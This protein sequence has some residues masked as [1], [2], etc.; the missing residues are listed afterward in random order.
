MSES[1][2]FRA[3]T[4]MSRRTLTASAIATLAATGLLPA[5]VGAQDATP[6][7][8]PVAFSTVP[9]EITDF[10]NDWPTTHANLANTRVA[11]ESGITTETVANLDVAWRYALDAQSGF[12][13]ITS[14]PIIQG[15][16]IYLADN[17]GAVHA[18]SRETG[19]LIWRT[20]DNVGTL[21]PNGVAVGYGYLASV[22]GDTAEVLVRKADTGELVWKVQLTT[23]G[24]VGITIAPVIYDG[25]VIVST[26]PGGNS[27][28]VYQGGATGIVYSLDLLT[29]VENWQFDTT[30]DEL[31]GNFAVNSGGGLWYPPAIDENGVLYMGVGNPGPWP[32]DEEFPNAVSRPGDNDYANCIVAL[33]PYAGKVLWYDNLKPHDL[34]DH[35]NQNSP[36]LGEVEVDGVTRKLVFASGKHGKIAAYDR[37]TGENI[38]TTLVGKHENDEVDPVPDEGLVV[39]PGFAG[40]V[41][42]PIAF[43]DGVILGTALNQ[44]SFFTPTGLDFAQQVGLPPTTSNVYAI[45]AATGEILWDNEINVSITGPGPTVAN[46]IFF[47]GAADGLVRGYAIETGELIWTFQASA[48]INAVFA[49]AGDELYIPAGYV[50]TESEYNESV[51]EYSPELIKLALS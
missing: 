11:L 10:A 7:A 27:K 16:T 35:D 13:A 30:V 4:Q 5:V 49:I 24:S 41:I 12:G 39:L 33:D 17:V 51:P 45:D 19:E 14:N 21:G 23:H 28:G 26:E 34:Y 3:S 22:L 47:I 42:A 48:G 20:D 18:I 6:E 32:G 8:T 37:E 46:D 36:V 40:G 31:W 25:Q 29:G 2:S 1:R 44:A 9:P 43:S 50:V 38:W 15:D